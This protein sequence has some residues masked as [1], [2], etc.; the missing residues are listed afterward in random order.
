MRVGKGWVGAGAGGLGMVGVWSIVSRGFEKLKKWYV[1]VD[2]VYVGETLFHGWKFSVGA[3]AVGCWFGF[4]GAFFGVWIGVFGVGRSLAAAV[5]AEIVLFG[6]ICMGVEVLPPWVVKFVSRDI[7]M[8]RG[9]SGK[10][11]GHWFLVPGLLLPLVYL[12]QTFWQVPSDNIIQFLN[13]VIVVRFRLG[14]SK[15]HSFFFRRPGVS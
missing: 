7:G 6:R 8:K 1:E 15:V 9:V 14:Q 13:M 5:I 2:V 11:L 12:C 10:T 3:W 4:W